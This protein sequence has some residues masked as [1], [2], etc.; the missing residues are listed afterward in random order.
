MG[1]GLWLLLTDSGGD[2]SADDETQL[3]HEQADRVN[4]RTPI[5][6]YCVLIVYD[7]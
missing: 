2:E 5:A 4:S 3:C 1:V 7:D 6:N